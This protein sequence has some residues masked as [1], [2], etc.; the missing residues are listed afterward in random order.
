MTEI[1]KELTGEMLTHSPYQ[2]FEAVLTDD[3]K[4]MILHHM[5]IG[6]NGIVLDADGTSA[7]DSLLA[8]MYRRKMNEV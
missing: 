7:L 2:A 5:S 8:E 4:I 6:Y 3:N 1:H